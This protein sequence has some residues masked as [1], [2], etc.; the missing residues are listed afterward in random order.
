MIPSGTLPHLERELL[1]DPLSEVG[2]YINPGVKPWAALGAARCLVLLGDPGIGKSDVF[3]RSLEAIRSDSSPGHQAI[4][5]RVGDYTGDA[6]IVNFFGSPAF[7]T[8]KNSESELSLFID[9][10]D[11]GLLRDNGWI[12]I[13]RTRLQDWSMR[14]EDVSGDGRCPLDRLRLRIS[15]RP[16]LWPD[17][18]AHLLQGFY[19]GRDESAEVADPMLWDLLPLREQDVR[20][21]VEEHGLDPQSFMREVEKAGAYSFSSRPL[22][23]KL[24]IRTMTKEGQLPK[25]HVEM[26][27]RGCSHLVDEHNR[28]R[29]ESVNRPNVTRDRRLQIAQR[30][31]AMTMFCGKPLIARTASSEAPSDS[32]ILTAAEVRGSATLEDISQRELDETLDSGLFSYQNSDTVRWTHPAF[33]AFLA[34]DWCQ[35]LAL[36]VVDMRNLIFLNGEHGSG[37]PQQVLWTAAWLCEINPQ[38]KKVIAR[39]SPILL[40]SLDPSSVTES[41]RPIAIKALVE[42]PLAPDKAR[43]LMKSGGRLNHPGVGPQLRR[44]IISKRFP[45]DRDIVLST[46][47]SHVNRL[48]FRKISPGLR[49]TPRKG[50]Q[51]A[52]QRPLP[53]LNSE[54][55]SRDSL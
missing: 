52:G 26:F 20:R 35:N 25:T 27:R 15:C 47:L 11:E 30:I 42:Y 17:S 4:L 1:P 38:V 14:A 8:W 32:A 31:A 54:M 41:L 50:I 22:T 40:L 9:G 21:A 49:L 46:L 39:T 33:A 23:L 43:E 51:F 24:L 34:A 6:L 19:G 18:L 3:Q 16:G 53:S 28:S 13:L 37:I 29:R 48:N 10:L 55:K 36:S 2:P 44:Y 45:M 7:E 5:C 12:G